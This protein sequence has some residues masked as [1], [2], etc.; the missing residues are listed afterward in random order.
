MM[1]RDTSLMAVYPQI[2]A[3][4]ENIRKQVFLKEN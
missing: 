4:P 2:K 1:N 3:M